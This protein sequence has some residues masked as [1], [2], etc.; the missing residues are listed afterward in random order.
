[1]ANLREKL[2][3]A[4][5]ATALVALFTILVR[6]MRE[7]QWGQLGDMLIS[8]TVVFVIYLGFTTILEMRRRRL[9]GPR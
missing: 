2:L 1:V 8:S 7:G 6:W 3:R 9:P 4:G 5:M